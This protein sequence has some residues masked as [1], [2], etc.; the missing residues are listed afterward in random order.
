MANPVQELVRRIHALELEL[1]EELRNDANE[2]IRD[3]DEKR[4]H[5]EQEVVEQQKRFRMGLLRYLWTA[6]IKSYFSAPFIYSLIVPLVLLDIFIS[7]YQF[8]C[9]PLYGIKK[10]RRSDHI[11]FD[12]AHLAYLNLFEKINCAYCSYANGLIGF[13]RE[14]AG[15]TEQYWCPIKHAKRAYLSHPYYKKF[16]EYGDAA[17]YHD[18][19]EKLRRTLS[20]NGH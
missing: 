12:R 7:S 5:F 15:K 13:C 18:T 3:F 4:I 20:S 19:L 16:A 2:M 9:F 10:V 6:D 11:I 1:E 14:V 17:N 8:I